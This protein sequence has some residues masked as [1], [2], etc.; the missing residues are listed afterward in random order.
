MYIYDRK[1]KEALTVARPQTC[2]IFTQ[3]QQS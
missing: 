1:R 2:T 3:V